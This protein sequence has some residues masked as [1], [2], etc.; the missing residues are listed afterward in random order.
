M[1]QPDQGKINS[2]KGLDV[3]TSFA[4]SDRSTC[5]TSVRNIQQPDFKVTHTCSNIQ[6][7]ISREHA[8][9]ENTEN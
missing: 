5:H 8:H 2:H 7:N 9:N 4:T 1:L 3:P 6:Q